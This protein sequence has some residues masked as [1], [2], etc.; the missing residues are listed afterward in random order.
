LQS[1]LVPPRVRATLHFG[2]P[3][4]VHAEL[5]HG[6]FQSRRQFGVQERQQAVAAVDQ[7]RRHAQ[8]GEHARVFTADHPGPDHGDRFGHLV[9]IEQFVRI[10]DA[11]VCERD[12]RWPQRVTADGDAHLVPAEVP[13]AGRRGHCHRVRVDEG[14]GAVD[15]RHAVGIQ[16]PLD[17]VPFAGFDGP[18]VAKEV[19]DG[20]PATQGEVDAVQ[21]AGANPGQ[22]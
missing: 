5:P 4:E 18:F 15:S 7:K 20:G 6:R 9:Y 16:Q 11:V 8:D 21:H 22:G 12:A 3:E 1:N 10:M 19:V 14:P 13:G 2:V 17:V